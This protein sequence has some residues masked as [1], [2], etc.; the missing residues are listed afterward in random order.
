MPVQM[1]IGGVDTQMRL[2]GSDAVADG[3]YSFNSRFAFVRTFSPGAIACA[4]PAICHASLKNSGG[5]VFAAAPRPRPSRA[6][7]KTNPVR[8]VST[9]A[10]AARRRIMRGLYGRRQ[11]ARHHLE[12]TRRE[13]QSRVER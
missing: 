10:I 5:G 1:L 3:P 7:A 8:P 6:C 12:M 4:G 2:S 11:R 13:T 9:M